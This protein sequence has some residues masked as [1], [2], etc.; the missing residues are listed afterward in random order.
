V[1]IKAY[2]SRAVPLSRPQRT[3]QGQAV[4]GQNTGVTDWKRQVLDLPRDL[5][6]VVKTFGELVMQNSG[7]IEFKPRYPQDIRQVPNYPLPSNP[8]QMALA[9][10]LKKRLEKLGLQATLDEH[11]NV[12][13]RLPSNLPMDFPGRKTV[14][15]L[16]FTSHLD[17]TYEQPNQGVVP[18]LHRNYKGDALLIAAQNHSGKRI[19]L[20]PQENP[21][22][23]SRVGH[24]IITASGDTLLGADAKAGVTEILESLRLIQAY[25]R[26]NPTKP[27]YYPEI[28]VAFVVDEESNLMGARTVDLKKLGA[29][30]AIDLDDTDPGRINVRSYFGH[31][32]S[33]KIQARTVHTA[34]LANMRMASP[35]MLAAQIAT[36]LPKNQL[37]E[38]KK[39]DIRGYLYL[40][41]LKA[42][43]HEAEMLFLVRDMDEAA[44][45]ARVNRVLQ[46]IHKVQLQAQGT[47][48]NIQWRVE[49]EYRNPRVDSRSPFVTHLVRSAK[50]AGIKPQITDFK[51]CTDAAVWS[52][53]GLPTVNLGSGW[54]NAHQL[55][56]WVSAQELQR[57][58][59]Y[60]LKVITDW[61]TQ[62]PKISAR[63]QGGN[64]P[65]MPVSWP[66]GKQSKNWKD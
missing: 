7:A 64:K 26:M 62:G 33:V 13:G 16:A 28:R 50:A 61:P 54:Q 11:Y 17:T 47:P 1:E 60:L 45:K 6:P 18:K 34:E 66:Q 52:E 59:H 8:E 58:S 21:A 41:Q 56:E 14:P 53:R 15:V 20:D 48:A 44:V 25:N 19:V 40:D 36:D 27:L 43:W 49:E 22:L 55:T 37:L 3:S 12:I 31:N 38:N 46:S 39:G 32:V 51:G 57:M 4:F 5:Q 23:K 29:D 35:M 10:D 65:F 42:N 63:L 9:T 2:G 24:D 30:F